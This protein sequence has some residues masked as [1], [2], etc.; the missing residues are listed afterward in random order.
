[1]TWKHDHILLVLAVIGSIMLYTWL[2]NPRIQDQPLA[3]RLSVMRVEEQAA[4]QHA[5]TLL[6]QLQNNPMQPAIWLELAAIHT[7][8]KHYDKAMAAI[9]GALLLLPIHPGLLMAKVDILIKQE[10]GLVT[11]KAASMLQ[12]ILQIAPQN[13]AALYY[14]GM[15]YIQSQELSKARPYWHQVQTLAAGNEPWFADFLRNKKDLLGE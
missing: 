1:M 13:V 7:R 2:G 8:Y 10:N 6:A 12:S 5:N 11:D 15:Y 3:E 14:M 4:M 9:N